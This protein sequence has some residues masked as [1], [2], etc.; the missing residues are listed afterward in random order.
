MSKLIFGWL[1]VDFVCTH[2]SA[3]VVVVV[4]AAQVVDVAGPDERPPELAGDPDDP[5]VGP[6]LLGEAV[7]LDLEV[8]VLGAERRDQLLGVGLGL[9]G[10]PVEQVLAEARLQAAGERDHAFGVGRD[11]LE[12]DRRLAA[13]KALEEPRRGELDEV[14]VAGRGRRQQR[15]VEAIEPS[16]ARAA[17]GPRRR[18]PR[19]RGS[20]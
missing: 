19:S 3:R 10:P 7:L 20:A 18:T 1:S 8:D 4:L 11:L 12:V 5:L 6:L 2:S 9:G 13:L 17:R 16:R 15:Q 14:A